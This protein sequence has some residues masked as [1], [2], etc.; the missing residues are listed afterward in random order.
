MPIHLTDDVIDQFSYMTGRASVTFTF[1]FFFFFVVVVVVMVEQ[2]E[3]SA[4]NA[5]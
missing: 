3:T 1:F 5:E 4:D 2:L